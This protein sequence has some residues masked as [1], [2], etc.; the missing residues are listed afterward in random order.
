MRVLLFLLPLVS[1]PALCAVDIRNTLDSQLSVYIKKTDKNIGDVQAFD[2]VLRT[3]MEA[4]FDNGTRFF[5]EFNTRYEIKDMLE[6]GKPSQDNSSNFNRPWLVSDNTEV[7][8][9]EFYIDGYFDSVFVRLGKQQTVW[10]Q[11]D[12]LQVLDVVNP[13][14]YREFISDDIENRRIPLWTANIEFPIRDWMM[15]LVWIPDQTYNQYPESGSEYA[16]TSPKLTPTIS[17]EHQVVLNEKERPNRILKDSDLGFRLTGFV[18]GWDIGLSYLYQY[19]NSR[20]VRQQIKDD[21]L[22]INSEYIRTHL[23]GSSFA[24]AL[25]SLSIRG[26]LAYISDSVPLYSPTGDPITATSN[27]SREIKA[28]VGLDYNGISDTLLSMQLFTSRMLDKNDYLVR[29]V[30]EQQISLL[31]KRNFLNQVLSIEGLIVHSLNDSD[32]YGHLYANY[33]FRSHITLSMGIDIYYGDKFGVFGQ[34]SEAS[35]ASFSVA[36]SF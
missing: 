36:Y 2:N 25:G 29:D 1:T 26:E 8:L 13:M 31:G 15:Q 4:A 23:L 20:G 11:S 35:K 5:A 33:K 18:G 6:P 17:G 34:F 9:R 14:R 19:N 28:V 12:G 7:E 32:G 10:G 22:T 16:I 27:D 21:V 3:K 24:K 30:T